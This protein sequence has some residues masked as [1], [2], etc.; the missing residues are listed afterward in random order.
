M[1]GFNLQPDDLNSVSPGDSCHCCGL[2]GATILWH[3]S[4]VVSYTTIIS[5]AAKSG[6]LAVAEQ[7]FQA[8][9]KHCPALISDSKEPLNWSGSAETHSN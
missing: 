6:N 7:W 2:C 4:Q 8:G 3:S 1:E 9:R 5:A